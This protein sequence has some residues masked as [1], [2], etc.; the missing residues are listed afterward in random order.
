METPIVR[1]Y[2]NEITSKICSDRTL[3][4]LTTYKQ[5]NS[6]DESKHNYRENNRNREACI[7]G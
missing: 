1:I 7:P 2:N 3:F 5:S 4:N 6:T